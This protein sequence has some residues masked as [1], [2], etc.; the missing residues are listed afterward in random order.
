M[1]Q[2]RSRGAFGRT[3]VKRRLRCIRHLKLDGLGGSGAAQLAASTKA[4]SIPAVTPAANTQFPSTTTRSLTG[5]APK[6]GSR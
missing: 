4:P 1:L 5:I 6:N 3:A 2:Y